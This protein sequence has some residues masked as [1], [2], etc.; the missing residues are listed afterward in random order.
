[1]HLPIVDEWYINIQ[2][3]CS[4][5][6]A[7]CSFTPLCFCMGCFSTQ[8]K[9]HLLSVCKL[10]CPAKPC[11]NCYLVCEVFL[12]TFSLFLK[13]TIHSLSFFDLLIH[14]HIVALIPLNCNI[15]GY[16][17]SRLL[18][19]GRDLSYFFMVFQHLYLPGT[20]HGVGKVCWTEPN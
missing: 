4:S 3:L 1:M 13:E 14:T 18:F 20:Q 6:N 12:D 8:N 10:I 2:L 5:L 17:F 11:S 9:L 7:Q 16:P 19:V 15:F